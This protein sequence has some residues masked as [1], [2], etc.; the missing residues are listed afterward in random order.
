MN[1]ISKAI[2][3]Y[4]N[5]SVPVKAAVWYTI[6]NVLQKGIAFLAVPI[7]VRL[8]TTGE[9]GR[10]MVFQSW[11]DALII[12]AT[13]NLYGGIFTKVMVDDPQGRDRF[14][15]C[16]Q[17]LSTL[18]TLGFLLIYLVA[19]DFWN[20]ILDMPTP[21][22]LLML[23][24]FLCVPSFLYWT[25]RQ[26][27]EYRYKRMVAVTLVVSVLIPVFSIL[28]LKV[29]QLRENAVIWGYLIIQIAVGAFFYVQ[30]LFRGKCVFDREIWQRALRYNLPLIPHYLS[31]IVLGQADRIMIKEICGEDKAGIYSLAYSVSL[32]LTVISTAIQSSL[33]PWMYE[34]LRQKDHEPIRRTVTG[35][36]AL[37][38][39]LTVGI[40]LVAPEIVYI[41]GTAEYAQAV[42]VIP[43]VAIG[44]FFTFCYG[45][46][47]NIEF[48]YSATG[49]VMIASTLGAVLNILLNALLIPRF[50]FIAAG[51]TTLA[52]YFFLLVLH[53]VFA[54]LICKKYMDGAK[55]INTASIG[56]MSAGLLVA[57][58]ICLTLYTWD[59]ARYAVLAVLLVAGLVMSRRILPVVKRLL[60]LSK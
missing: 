3:K 20:G 12:V 50:G 22:V 37:T 16:V 28:L 30:N 32:L 23:G 53:C 33:T 4:R 49:L 7:Y 57:M 9:Y 25:V 29:T 45:M 46:Y 59:L 15:S 6:C 42:W 17:G 26:R 47:A 56:L 18:A 60:R 5:L 27:V 34:K 24:Y 11:R 21:T 1:P 40:M 19:P 54:R 13:L 38:A 48:Y 55:V 8:L 35:L 36:G 14:T 2:S 39:I 43:A 52:S 44:V 58:G 10:Y 51:Y 41:L 31:M